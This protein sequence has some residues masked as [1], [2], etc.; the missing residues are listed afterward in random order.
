MNLRSY[1]NALTLAALFPVAILATILG[2]FLVQQERN[3]F[4]RGTEDRVLALLT[5][6]DSEL[7]ASTDTLRAL[8]HIRSLDQGNLR[9]FRESAAQ[10]LATHDD[11]LTINLALPNGQQVVNVSVPE[12]MPLP[13]IADDE[14]VLQRLF[15]TLKPVVGDL[16]VG[17]VTKR[18]DFAVRMPV[19]RNGQ[20]VY[21][22]SAVVNPRSMD[23]LVSAQ[24]L[25]SDW[26]GMVIDRKGRIVARTVKPESIGQLADE[27]LRA[28][29]ARSPSG[30][31]RGSNLEGLARYRAYQR[32][33][34]TGWA[35][36]M[37]IPIEA[38]DGTATRAIWI[39][40]LALAGTVLLAL[41]LA[42]LIGRRIAGPITALAAAT[43]RVARGEDLQ[44]RESGRIRE[45]QV[46]ETALRNAAA[47]QSALRRTEE[48]TRSIVDHVLD[49][50]ITIDE[51][52]NIESFNRAAET[53]F[54]YGAAEVIGKNVK[55]LMP[56]PYRAGH[57]GYVANYM[58]TGEAKIIGVGREVAGQRK[59]GT[60]FPMDL[61]V[62]E[63]RLGTKRHF[64]GIVRDITERKRTEQA[65][66]DADRHK[67]VF[68]AMLGHELRNPLA[69]LTS[70]AHV[71]RAG[72]PG[73]VASVGAQEVIERQTQHMVRLIEDLLDITRIRLGKLSL[74][75]ETFDL[76]NLVSD[77]TQAWRAAGSLAGRSGLS[78][79]LSPAWVYADRARLEQIFSN[80]LAN[81][82]KF[83]PAGEAIEVKVW[84][85]GQ[86]AK[87]Q[88]KDNGRGIAPQSLNSI[89]EPFVQGEQRL[90]RGD[91]G[92][93]L[94][95]ALVKRLAELHD[96]SV[97]AESGGPGQGALFTV[98]FPASVPAHERGVPRS[99]PETGTVRRRVL[100]IEDKD[101]ARQMLCAA[102]AMEGHDVRAAEDG[103][104]GLSVAAESSPDAV[105]ID[106]GLPDMDGYEV[107][108]R[109]R[110]AT[111]GA[112][113]VLIA[114]TAYGREDD[115]GRAREAGFHAH[116][117]KPA[118]AER[119]TQLI[120][121]FAASN[122]AAS[123]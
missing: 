25:P 79:N 71:L 51:R 64:T 70:A 112:A 26:E 56:E 2:A 90:E 96:G 72:A 5:A 11:W 100:V 108:R 104:R 1:L 55:I 106:I 37:A 120:A 28:A 45:L 105:I 16:V 103:A 49:G 50:I 53:L 81:A 83:T 12:G 23:R 27:G 116:L 86:K 68:L 22:L 31:F 15:E 98:E 20:L 82:L 122:R 110:A 43:D 54:G 102:L 52:G 4:R 21:I 61:A 114:L 6:V 58:R 115:Q 123:A 41:A 113:P 65:L 14:E 30:W 9:L 34:E 87:L 60:T 62:S 73:D 107:A 8:A 46:L 7:K 95:L 92:L 117:V 39:F 36:A 97:C 69:A 76:A 32:S 13:K 80:L 17:P 24:R 89:F 48:R 29:L 93:G 44:I 3:T 94:G 78:L 121:K 101:D 77:V 85:Q 18:W 33:E 47:A 118:T 63:F 88:V 109:L 84:Q 59:D 75:R 99:K 19:V 66:R 67:D 35:F 74:K 119:L 42:R 111:N 40:G 10:V 57:D 91:G 38:V